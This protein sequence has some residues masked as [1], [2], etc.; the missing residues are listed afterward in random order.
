MKALLFACWLYFCSF[1]LTLFQKNCFR[2][3][4]RMS[5]GWDP[6][7][8][9]IL[10]KFVCK[11]YQQTKKSPLERRVCLLQFS[12]HFFFHLQ[13]LFKIC[14]VIFFQARANQKNNLFG[15]QSRCLYS[16]MTF[17]TNASFWNKCFFLEQ[18]K[19]CIK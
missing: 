11:G 16:A 12:G 19:F 7:W 17:E 15:K 9:L 1:L 6:E 2:N 18:I 13:R 3:T 14:G 10:V 4:F 8:D 5:N